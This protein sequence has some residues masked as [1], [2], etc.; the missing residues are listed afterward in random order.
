MPSYRG[1]RVLDCTQGKPNVYF[2]QGSKETANFLTWKQPPHHD[3]ASTT[4]DNSGQIIEIHTLSPVIVLRLLFHLE[5]S[6]DLDNLFNSLM[7]RGP[8]HGLLPYPVHGSP[9]KE[10]WCFSFPYYYVALEGEKLF[11]GQVSS[12]L[13]DK[14]LFHIHHGTSVVALSLGNPSHR[15]EEPNGS[16]HAEDVSWQIL[17]LT[18]S[19]QQRLDL[20]CLQNGIEAYL[21]AV[22]QQFAAVRRDLR[23]V[24][25]RIASLAVPDVST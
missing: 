14:G 5:R 18:S 12:R 2:I 19:I 21:S 8:S 25:N 3:H 6:F 23:A 16:T 11:S 15:G 13:Y 10:S 1:R 22:S 17:I 24:A 4:T 20:P 9:D 7:A